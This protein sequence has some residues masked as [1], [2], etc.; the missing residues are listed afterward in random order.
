MP[1]DNPN[2]GIGYAAEFQSSALPW[3]TSSV[4]P[5]QGSPI[6]IDF[7]KVT[8]FIILSNTGASTLSFG[9]TYNGVKNSSNKY[10][11]SGSQVI[12]IEARVKA[13]WLQGEGGNPSYS[14]FAGLTTVR[15][16][17][18]PLLTGSAPDGSAWPGVG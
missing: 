12:S 18:M 6:E 1:L 5:N 17:D 11:L 10:I 13:L 3:V 9:F 2:G 8:R 4:A 7:P 15:S 14:L 16:Q